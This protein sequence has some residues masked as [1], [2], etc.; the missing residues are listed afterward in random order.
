[1]GQRSGMKPIGTSGGN[2]GIGGTMA[3]VCQTGVS[4]EQVT[5][6]RLTYEQ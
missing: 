1:M 5:G 3:A 2:H 4:E 6:I